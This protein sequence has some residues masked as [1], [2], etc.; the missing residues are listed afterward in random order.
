VDDSGLG[1][2]GVGGKTGGG[3]VKL[4]DEEVMGLSSFEGN[5]KTS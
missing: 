2:I 1:S 5:V 4:S 3:R